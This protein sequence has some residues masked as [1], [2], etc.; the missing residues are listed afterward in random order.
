MSQSDT[1][2]E[3]TSDELKKRGRLTVGAMAGF[4][5]VLAWAT[6]RM[7][8]RSSKLETGDFKH[9][10]WAAD[11]MRT[12]ADPYSSGVLEKCG[13]IYPPLV[14]W[15]L[16]PLTLLGR[17]WGERAWGGA[18]LVLTCVCLWLSFRVVSSRL[19]GP[20]DRLT[21]WA[22]LLASLFLTMDQVRWEFEQGQ[23]DTVAL[24]GLTAGLW[25]LDRFPAAAGVVLGLALQVK[26]QA[27]IMLPYLLIRRRW[28][29]A[30]AM[31]G[32][33][34]VLAVLPALTLGWATTME[35][36]ATAYGYLFGLLRSEPDPETVLLY[37]ITWVESISLPSGVARALADAD[38]SV[39]GGPLV[40]IVGLMAAATFGVTWWMFW[41][42]GF[43]L[44]RERGGAYERSDS[45]RAATLI[46]WC[47]LIV[48][49]LVFS[50]QTTVRHTFLLIPVNC[51]AAYVLLVPRPRVRKWP[52]F[53][54][55]VIFQLATR[56]PPGD[57]DALR[58]ALDWWRSVSGVSWCLLLMWFGLVW[59]GLDYARR[60]TT[61]EFLG[62]TEPVPPG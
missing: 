31:L 25:F 28:A 47:G 52:L 54:G 50:P 48:A 41:A 40:L 38:G 29:A 43:R 24:L 27:L 57:V 44:F 12:G 3:Y 9:F 8:Q 61:G 26:H 56:L 7:W 36:L 55:V 58:P 34:A 1:T 33:A 62:A 16:Q 35:H 18:N 22:V 19:R 30:G 37:P 51:A 21:V 13:Y 14:A 23:T 60:D 46:E 20:R 4:I 15:L 6:S 10:Y 45:A 59:C 11:A 32:G 2:P 5:A 17:L 53:V 49:L 42:R 39:P